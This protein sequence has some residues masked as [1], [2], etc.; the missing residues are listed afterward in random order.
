M[1]LSLPYKALRREVLK[2]PLDVKFAEKCDEALN[3]YASPEGYL[4]W[5]DYVKVCLLTGSAEALKRSYAASDVRGAVS[6]TS[7]RR[8]IEVNA[9]ARFVSKEIIESFAETSLPELPIEVANVFPYV[10]LMLPRHA[11]YDFEGDEVIAIMVESGKLYSETITTEDKHI[12]QTFFPNEKP[13]SEEVRGATGIQVTTITSNGIDVLQE[14]ISP[15]AKSWHESN[16]RY[17]G[18]SK[19]E[20]K[21]TETILRIAINSLLVHLYE[22]SLIT[23]DPRTPSKGVGFSNASKQPL[24][25]TWI[26]KTF[27]KIA[28]SQ[29]KEKTP[30]AESPSRGA[31]RSHWRRGHWH[32]VCI[33]AGRTERRVQWFKPIYVNAH[34]KTD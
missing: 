25:P 12:T 26:G 27:K 23:V 31:V 1:L 17:T 13:A 34:M 10:H 7:Y 15:E 4:K 20:N 32:S 29:E 5:N 14:F 3:A 8:A 11:V 9:C 6:G 21:N 24:A 19:Y 28:V 22:P 33:G 16:I 18:N 30:S 2:N